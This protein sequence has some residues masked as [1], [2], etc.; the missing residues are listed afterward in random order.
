MTREVGREGHKNF[1]AC[2]H[3]LQA[4]IESLIVKKPSKEG[5]PNSH[6][7]I[8]A[9]IVATANIIAM[10][11]Y[12]RRQVLDPDTSEADT[13]RML[14]EEQD[15]GLYDYFTTIRRRGMLRAA[16]TERTAAQRAYT[17]LIKEQ[18]DWAQVRGQVEEEVA[19]YNFISL[20][21]ESFLPNHA[22]LAKTE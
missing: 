17:H 12:N 8:Q 1:M 9:T 3:S 16:A 15:A 19:T 2:S 22:Q 21:T 18:T 6:K 13:A 7:I 4:S 20:D 5:T 11:K 10:P 14:L